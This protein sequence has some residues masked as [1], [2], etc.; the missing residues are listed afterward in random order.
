MHFD[1]EKSQCQ[2]QNDNISQSSTFSRGDRTTKLP[3]LNFAKSK[4]Q[5]GSKSLLMPPLNKTNSSPPCSS[6]ANSNQAKE[7][8]ENLDKQK[9]QALDKQP[10]SADMR[11]MSPLNNSQ[12]KSSLKK[13]EIVADT[14]SGSKR[15]R[16][17]FQLFA[18]PVEQTVGN[19]TVENK[20]FGDINGSNVISESL[21]K[22]KRNAVSFV[23]RPKLSKTKSMRPKK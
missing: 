12:T 5:S 7:D 18:K 21:P 22:P 23:D 8:Q 3:R 17:S 11:E 1:R 9:T 20:E 15:Q 14:D 4:K 13:R 6:G 2:S 10:V 16:N 19:D